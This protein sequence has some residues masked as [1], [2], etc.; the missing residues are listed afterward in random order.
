MAIAELKRT[1]VEIDLWSIVADLSGV[2]VV[3]NVH[4]ES[5]KPIFPLGVID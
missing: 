1:V 4:D 3:N 2:V 5:P